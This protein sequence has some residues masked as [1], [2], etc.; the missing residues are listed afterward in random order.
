MWLK[1]MNES[2]LT[3]SKRD[4]LKNKTFGIPETRSYPMPDKEHV[5]YAIQMFDR[6][7]PKNRD[8]LAKN[9]IKFI[10]KYDMED[11]IHVGKDNGFSKY[12]KI[13]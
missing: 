3:K 2:T 6:C 5:K 7:N 1:V 13:N 11:E 10:K 12:W 8:K 4:R 9:I